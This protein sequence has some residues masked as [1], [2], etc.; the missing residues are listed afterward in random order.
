MIEVFVVSP[1]T[2][3]QTAE[4][5]LQGPRTFYFAGEHGQP[6]ARCHHTGLLGLGSDDACTMTFPS[7]DVY[8][9]TVFPPQDSL[10]AGASCASR[11]FRWG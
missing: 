10:G 5:L 1:P 9:C 4:R 8:R 6:V 7:G 3:I 2:P 11:P